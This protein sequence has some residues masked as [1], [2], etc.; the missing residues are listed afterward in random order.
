LNAQDSFGQTA[1]H[2]AVDID[3]DSVVQAN[4]PLADM[5][6]ET[7]RLMLAL[8]ANP[9]ICDNHG[10]TPRDVAAFYGMNVLDKFDRETKR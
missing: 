3:I 6:F 1:L 2:I 7:A 5:Q 4:G 9:D 10:R 8:G